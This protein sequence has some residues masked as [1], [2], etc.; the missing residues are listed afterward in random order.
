VNAAKNILKFSTAGEAGLQA[1]G[2]GQNLLGHVSSTCDE[3]RTEP[4]KFNE[5]VRLERAAEV[6]GAD[7]KSSA[8]AW[9]ATVCKI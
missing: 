5:A 9:L 3:A 1:R 8:I 2:A 6:K 7:S 4:K